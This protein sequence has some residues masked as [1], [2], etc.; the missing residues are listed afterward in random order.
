MQNQINSLDQR[1]NRLEDKLD[2]LSK[3]TRDGFDSLN[4][5]KFRV[6]GFAAA[7]S[8]ALGVILKLLS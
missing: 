5:F 7:G 3:E 4:A 2:R 6:T 8:I 1:L